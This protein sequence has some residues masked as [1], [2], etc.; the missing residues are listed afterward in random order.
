MRVCWG[1]VLAA[2]L[3][4]VR[5]PVAIAQDPPAVDLK[6]PAAVARAYEAACAKGEVGAAL[7]LLAPDDPLKSA[8]GGIVSMMRGVT[9]GEGGETSDLYTVT[10]LF[11]PTGKGLSDRAVA[12]VTQEGETARARVTVSAQHDLLLGRQ[13]DG[14]WRVRLAD[15]IRAA[16]PSGAMWVEGLA[17]MGSRPVAGPEA[18]P[19]ASGSETQLSVLGQA[20]MQYAAA[21]DNK[22]PDAEKWMDELKPYVQDASAFKCPLFP[23]Q[24][25]GYTM[26]EDLSGRPLP[27][28]DWEVAD[29]TPVL[30][31]WPAGGRNAHAKPEAL[32]DIKSP[33]ADGTVVV[34]KATQNTEALAAGMALA[35]KPQLDTWKSFERLQKLSQAAREYATDHGNTWPHADRWTDELQPYVLDPALFRC[36]AAPTLQCGYAMNDE[37]S[38]QPVG[39]DWEAQDHTLFLFEWPTGERNAH[40]TPGTLAKTK[41]LRPDGVIVA[42]KVSSGTV[43][44]APGVRFDEMVEAER[45][46]SACTD[47]LSK[48]AQAARKYLRANGGKLPGATTWQADLA[49]YLVGEGNVDDLLTCPAAPDL[50]HAYAINRDVAGKNIA[51]L[52]N[53]AGVVVFFESDL[54]VPNAAGSPDKDVPAQPRHRTYGGDH[55][56][57][58]N[59]VVTLSGETHEVEVKP[60]AA[61]GK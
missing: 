7:A 18:S 4:V 49:P 37:L 1:L 25:F 59:E 38:G 20:L 47:H 28:G 56:A 12:T 23:N 21:H 30:F 15:T 39:E 35:D 53:P 41:S 42:V 34:L 40:A 32:R 45:G 9:V 19:E 55:A 61:E 27:T 58:I 36:P 60:K 2:L 54:N 57:A 44:I 31:E 10:A 43:E 48:L 26:N 5:A 6:D 51:E 52:M 22:L 50:K 14:T 3:S 29:R 8:L 46:T 24:E 33:R 16:L 17:A 11:L 13:P